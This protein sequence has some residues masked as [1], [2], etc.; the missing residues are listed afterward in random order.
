MAARASPLRHAPHTAEE[1]L[2]EWDRPYAASSAPIPVASLRAAKYFPPVSRIDSAA[3][4][5]NLDVLLR[6]ARDVRR[7]ARLTPRYEPSPA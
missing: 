7:R 6:A 3:G 5:R 1:L 2:G 4:D